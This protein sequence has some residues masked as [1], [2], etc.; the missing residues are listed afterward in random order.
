MEGQGGGGGVEIKMNPVT[1]ITSRGFRL[2]LFVI[3]S[4]VKAT[5]SSSSIFTSKDHRSITLCV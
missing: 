2:L 3:D 4:Q 5:S 1:S